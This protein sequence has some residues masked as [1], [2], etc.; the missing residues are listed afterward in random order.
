MHSFDNLI[1]G[2]TAFTLD[3]LR[4][5]EARVAEEFQTSGATRLVIASRVIQLQ[6]VVSAVGMFSIFDAELQGILACPDGFRGA[7][8][9]LE[10]NGE[11]ELK[12][13][14]REL[15]LAVNVLKHGQ[16]RSYDLLVKDADSL[17]FRIKRPDESFFL[18][19]DVSEV[20]TL[21]QVDD[22]FVKMCAEVIWKVSE[23]I[24][25]AGRR[26]G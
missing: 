19:G 6:K 16:G 15:Q 7:E 20:S 8:K 18:E 3:A 2:C 21:I 17:P 22:E 9:F 5:A 10:D 14:F 1:Q 12:K 13:Q 25:T 23:I 26:D 11:H 24:R 4:E